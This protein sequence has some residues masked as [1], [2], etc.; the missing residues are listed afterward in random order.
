MRLGKISKTFFKKT[1]RSNQ[2]L[3]LQP[4]PSWKKREEGLLK[5][6]NEFFFSLFVFF[7]CD[8]ISKWKRGLGEERKKKF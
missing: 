8:K 6:N 7:H 3:H 1:I 4:L 2:M 5:E